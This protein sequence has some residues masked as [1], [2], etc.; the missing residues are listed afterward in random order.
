MDKRAILFAGQGAQFVGMG[1]DL[2]KSSNEAKEVFDLANEILEVDIKEL[3]FRGPKQDLDKTLHTQPSIFTYNMAVYAALQKPAADFIAGH[4]LGEVCAAVAVDSLSLERGFKVIKERAALMQKAVEENDGSMIAVIG[5]EA[6][7]IAKLLEPLDGVYLS[8]FN[9]ATQTT[10]SGPKDLLTEAKQLLEEE[11]KMV[12]V[13]AVSG[14]FHSPYMQEAA[15]GFAEYLNNIDFKDSKTPLVA[16]VD[17]KPKTKGADIREALSQ[18]ISS[19]VQFSQTLELMHK[20]KVNTFV[21]VGPAKTLTNFVKR[22]YRQSDVY[23]TEAIDSVRTT[24]NNLKLD[25]R[26]QTPN[27]RNNPNKENKTGDLKTKS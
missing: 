18:Q 7:K 16:N 19:P 12:V 5:L 3:C 13:L 23:T 8:N 22:A 4:S 27:I 24:F 15:N 9:S 10:V 20:G 14:A 17:A 1:K 25:I 21:E 26:Y 11:A 2:Y 6:D